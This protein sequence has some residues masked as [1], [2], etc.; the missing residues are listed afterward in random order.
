MKSAIL[1][2]SLILLIGC[3]MNKVYAIHS[4]RFV[5]RLID[6]ESS[7]PITNASVTVTV[8]KNESHSWH[9]SPKYEHISVS[10]DT[11]G[12][13][14]I[15]FT[16]KSNQFSWE[17][18]TPNHYSQNF[19][20]PGYEHFG[21]EI[22]KSD[23]LDINT[24]TVEGLAKFNELRN[25]YNTDY[26]AYVEKFAPKSVAYTNNVVIRSASFYPK[27]N[28]QSM[29]AYG[30]VRSMR[31]R[32]DETLTESNGV[33]VISYPA[34]EI[35]LK[36]GSFVGNGTNIGCVGE[37]ADFRLKRFRVV[38]NGVENF[39]GWVEFDAGCGAYKRKQTG[40]ASFPTTYQADLAEAYCSKLMF[41]V[42]RNMETGRII[43]KEGLLCDDEYIVMRTR[44]KT[45]GGTNIW[46]YSKIMGPVYVRNAF[47]FKQSVFNPR[48]NDTNLEFDQENNLAER[49][50]CDLYP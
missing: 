19:F 48:P 7:A 16:F 36:K 31:L 4:G 28:P 33:A 46:H 3:A 47:I 2:G 39:Y 13:A 22:I 45:E 50:Q 38:T 1:K 40:D 14:D 34:V 26:L 29:Y 21:A 49:D 18:Q 23:Y 15:A 12:V 32:F 10:T 5:V 43:S 44:K 11:N 20:H 24:N 41:S 42:S 6:K 8:D 17:V 9:V 37:T 27:R 35:D 30:R 25:L